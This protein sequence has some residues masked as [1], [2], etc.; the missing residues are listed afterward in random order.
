MGDRRHAYPHEGCLAISQAGFTPE[1]IIREY[2]T[3][4]KADV[5]A[6]LAHEENL[7]KQA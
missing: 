5:E 3:L 6:A 2:P 4:T 1:V 7:A